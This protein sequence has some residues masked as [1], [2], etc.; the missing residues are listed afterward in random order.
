MSKTQPFFTL[1]RNAAIIAPNELGKQDILIAGSKI[2]AIGKNLELPQGYDGKE[3][4]LTD[5]TVL[6]GFIDSHV[7]MIGGGGEGGYATRTPEIVLSKVTTSGV[8]TLIG[9][10]GTDGTTRH[11]ESL[12]AK[13]RGLEEEGLS[14]YI[15]TGAYEIPTPTITGSVR[16]DIIIIDKIIGTGEI[17]MSD[18]RSAQPTKSEYQKLAA[19]ARVGGML[20]GKAGII[21]MHLGDGADGMKLLYE[22]TANGEIPKAQFLPT[23]VNRNAK[24][25]DE[26]IAWAKQGGMMDITSGVSPASGSSKAIKPSAAVKKALV[27]GVPLT[28]ITMSSDGNGSMPIFDEKG[29]TIGVGVASQASM[30]EEVRDMVQAEGISLSDAVQIVTS[31]VAHVL[32]LRHKGTITIGADADIL[33]I[34]KEFHLKEVWCKGQHMVENG[35][36]IVFGTFEA[37]SSNS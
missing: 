1:L 36:P 12:L 9:C 17:A 21:D 27:K 5:H 25:L 35:K 7:H 32:K 2:A 33:V 37:S 19:E 31:N 34:N 23:H 22:I 11:M 8:T 30:L 29:N 6:P 13:A 18:H 26:S 20:S 15:Y 3:I 16:K 10:L 14:T 4:N 28:Q 24:L